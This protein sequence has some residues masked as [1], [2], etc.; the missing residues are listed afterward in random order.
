MLNGGRVDRGSAAEVVQPAVG[1]TQG[2]MSCHQFRYRTGLV[3]GCEAGGHGGPDGGAAD[4]EVSAPHAV[5]LSEEA[6]HSAGHTLAST[7]IIAGLR[8]SGET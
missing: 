3:V 1:R 6:V 8:L 5:P 4:E 7:S 2:E